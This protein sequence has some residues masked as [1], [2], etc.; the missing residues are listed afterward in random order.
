MAKEVHYKCDICGGPIQTKIRNLEG[1]AG[2][3]ESTH[4]SYLRLKIEQI[5]V[6]RN[7]PER[8]LS[9]DICTEC[10]D[11]IKTIIERRTTYGN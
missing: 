11:A 3:F 5:D 10:E 7:F 2:G 9:L 8:D 4:P 1:P 6:E